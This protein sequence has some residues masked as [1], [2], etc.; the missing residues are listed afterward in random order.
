FQTVGIPILRGR[1]FDARPASRTIIISQAF[2]KEL[3]R[4]EDPIGK[5]ITPADP[6]KGPWYQVVAVVGDTPTALGQKPLPAMYYPVSE[7]W[8]DFSIVVSTAGDP[9]GAASG[10]RRVMY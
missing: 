4:N 9:A 8:N 2:A 7:G 5:R 1:T 3:F 10:L 6:V